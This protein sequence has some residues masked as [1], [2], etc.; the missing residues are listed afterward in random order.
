MALNQPYLHPP[1]AIA[2][3][4]YVDIA[5]GTG[6]VVFYGSVT[7]NN[8]ATN[9]YL[10]TTKTYSGVIV[11]SATPAGTSYTKLIDA[12]F[13]V[14]FNTPK[15]VKGKA[16]LSVTQGAVCQSGTTGV[17]VYLVATLKHYDGT[18]ETTLGSAQTSTA[19]VSTPG[20]GATSKSISFV[21]DIASTQ[22]FKANDTLRLTLECWG[23]K[24][25][26]AS[27]NNQAGFGADPM[28]RND[29]SV[30]ATHFKVILD[31]DT[32]ILQLN[33]PFRVDL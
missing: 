25:A 12:D 21:F 9:Y 7:K 11:P 19:F 3:Y 2:S 8:A 14:V 20:S 6:I 1:S 32:T 24:A 4:D 5:E 28:D 31:T 33:V 15:L 16:Y 18:T 30:G 10:T 22:Q 17:G 29:D 26:D 23:K 13:D 27:G